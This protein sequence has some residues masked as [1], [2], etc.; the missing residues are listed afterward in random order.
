MY[1]IRY[2]TVLARIEKF[3]GFL[4]GQTDFSIGKANATKSQ[5]GM[6]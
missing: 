1:K 6:P 2:E 4:K 5:D 3:N